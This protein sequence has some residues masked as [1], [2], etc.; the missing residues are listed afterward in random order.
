VILKAKRK[1]EHN[2]HQLA[3]PNL[4]KS[5]TLA[6]Y[7]CLFNS[8]H[9]KLC[10]HVWLIA[11]TNKLLKK[12][13]PG[14][15]N[16]FCGLNWDA[17]LNGCELSREITVC[18]N[19]C[20]RKSCCGRFCCRA[21]PINFKKK[22][23]TP[24]LWC[25]FARRLKNGTK[26]FLYTSVTAQLDMTKIKYCVWA[27]VSISLKMLFDKKKEQIMW[28]HFS[29]QHW[30]SA[31]GSLSDFWNHPQHLIRKTCHVTLRWCQT[32]SCT[33]YKGIILQALD[34]WRRSTRIDKTV[35]EFYPVFSTVQLWMEA[36]VLLNFAANKQPEVVRKI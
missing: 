15:L 25:H 3:I 28:L 19:H 31:F 20:D 2:M 6:P 13:N 18:Q 4:F 22:Q 12:L 9:D 11:N 21:H 8:F 32:V 29:W 26:F 33:S 30:G 36:F 5:W 1:R 7:C 27:G 17:N 35:A 16:I 34:K 10:C 23:F 14:F 24:F